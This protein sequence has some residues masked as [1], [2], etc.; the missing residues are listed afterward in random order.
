MEPLGE[1][2]CDLLSSNMSEKSDGQEPSGSVKKA[3]DIRTAMSGS[4]CGPAG[5]GQGRSRRNSPLSVLAV[6]NDGEC[7]CQV[8]GSGRSI[9]PSLVTV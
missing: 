6:R 8:G 7:A 3:C 9:R 1:M 4:N 2:E 5:A